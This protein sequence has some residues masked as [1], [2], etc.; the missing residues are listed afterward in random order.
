M[1]SLNKIVSGLVMLA[2]FATGCENGGSVDEQLDSE[3]GVANLPGGSRAYSPQCIH[4]SDCR[5]PNS[6]T[7]A[8][9]YAGQCMYNDSRCCHSNRE[10]DDG[11]ACTGDSCSNG[12]CV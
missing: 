5:V 8:I 4:A 11:N 1:S 6:C 3:Q 7:V 2:V 10:C 12:I 9:C